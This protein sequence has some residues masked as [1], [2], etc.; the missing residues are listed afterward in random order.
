MSKFVPSSVDVADLGIAQ[1]PFFGGE[2]A[3]YLSA[4]PCYR[5]GTIDLTAAG[6]GTYTDDPTTS[7]TA[8]NASGADLQ[9]MAESD[10]ISPGGQFSCWIMGTNASDAV[11]SGVA[12]F[13]PPSW[14]YN[15]SYDFQQGYAVDVDAGV[16]KFKTVTGVALIQNGAKNMKLKV[17]M[18]PALTDFSLVGCSTGSDFTD[19]A[20]PSKAIPCGM[21][22]NAFTKKGRSEQATLKISSNLIS[23]GDGLGRM[24]GK[25]CTAMLVGLKEDA[26]ITDRLVF[27]E[28][29]PRVSPKIGEGDNTSSVD[30]DGNY[31]DC[32]YFIA[33]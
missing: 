10:I 19:N 18:L 9:V 6:T 2:F 31:T 33:P 29:I 28:Y 25:R 8:V 17:L 24:S 5:I 3:V 14:V 7:I 20:R 13:S 15:Q 12:R 23:F 21:K 26:V 11:C 27:T 4:K 16:N 30:A 22:G 1:A 32:A